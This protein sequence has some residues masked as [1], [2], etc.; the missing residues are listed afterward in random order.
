L[1]V[2]TIGGIEKRN[3]AGV[4]GMIQALLTRPEGGGHGRTKDSNKQYNQHPKI[5]AKGENENINDKVC[6]G[7][8][9]REDTEL[10]CNLAI[11]HSGP[12]LEGREYIE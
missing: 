8:E 5:N 6:I 3:N 12:D 11:K 9:R 10:V 7:G 1:F 4:I 2:C